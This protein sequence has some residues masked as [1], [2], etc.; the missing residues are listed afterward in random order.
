MAT[1]SFTGPYQYPVRTPPIGGTEPVQTPPIGGQHPPTNWLG[2]APQQP[3]QPQAPTYSVDQFQQWAQGKYGRQ[4]TPQELQQI[5]QQVGYTGGPIS[6]QQ[7]TGAQTFADQL[8]QQQGWRPQGPQQPQAQTPF[9]QANIPGPNLQPVQQDALQQQLR[10]Q[11]M[12]QLGQ[13]IGDPTQDPIYQQQVNAFDVASQREQQRQ[14]GQLAERNAASGTLQSG[15]FNSQVANLGERFGE[16]RTG[17]AA[18][19]AGKRLTEQQEQLNRAQ[20]LAR[21][22]GDRDLEQQLTE[23]QQALGGYGQQL[24]ALMQQRGIDLSG[25][26]GRGDLDLRR[27]LGKGQLGLGLLSTMLGNEQA[28]NRLGF[29]YTQLQSLMNRNAIMD[30]LGG[31]Y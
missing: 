19:L 18:D 10:D 15:G 4:A 21:M 7:W 3:Q 27:Y 26:L 24:G 17:F 20:Q 2:G 22:L 16:Q 9:Q 25:E 14:R 8:A 28:N 1:N 31:S 11:I 23:R 5:G 29:D 12:K 13:P 30:L 6:Q